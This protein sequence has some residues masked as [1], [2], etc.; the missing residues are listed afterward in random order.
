MFPSLYLKLGGAALVLAMLGWHLFGDHR[1]RTAL[2]EARA[3]VVLLES[4]TA[5][6]EES[7]KQVTIAKEQ[8][9]VAITAAEAQR[10]Q[11]QAELQVTLKKLRSQKPPTECKAAIEWSIENKGDLQW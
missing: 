3:Q 8:L 9:D 7:L 2:D 10:Q 6:L 1:T 11:V 5:Q 4:K